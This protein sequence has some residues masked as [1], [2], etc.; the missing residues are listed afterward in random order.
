[1]GTRI[2][3]LEKTIGDL[4]KQTEQIEQKGKPSQKPPS[5]Q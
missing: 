5:E 4:M 2:D 3:D 1:M